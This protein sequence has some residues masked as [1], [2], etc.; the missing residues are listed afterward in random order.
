MPKP[1]IRFEPKTD[2]IIEVILYLAR[3]KDIELDIYKVVK[4]VY[5]ADVLHLNKYGRP[6]TYDQMLAMEYG[7]VPSTTYGIL[8]EDKRLRSV[9]YD[10]LPFDFIRRGNR[11]YIENPKRE[12][13]MKLFSKSDLKALEETI[14]EHGK[15][16]FRQLY[17]MTHEHEAYKR[18]W[19]RKGDG[20]SSPIRF[21]DLLD[22]SGN[23]AERVDNM[24]ATC[25]H[26]H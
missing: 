9:D 10:D 23:K 6:I 2:K 14:D 24:R 18:A 20:K 5:L 26:V 11:V 1:D 21:E 4:L 13:N 12:L 3:V 19:A 17:D 7:P 8:K 15:K 25:G 16:T 22:E